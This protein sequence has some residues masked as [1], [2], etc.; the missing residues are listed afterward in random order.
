MSGRL[1][2]PAIGLEVHVQLAT[3]TK[4][5]C[6]DSAGFGAPPNT[7][8][9]PVCLGL[10][11]SLPVPNAAAV[12]LAVRAALALHC[13]VHRTSRF[14]RKHYFYP[15]L[16]KGYQITQ[17]EQ[18]LATAGWLDM[19]GDGAPPHRIRIRRVHLE[20]DA[21]RSVHDR[22]A[23]RTAIDL[24]RAGVPLIE[25]V[26]EPE[27][28]SPA[29]AR[30]FLARL[31]QLLQYAGVSDCDME[32]GGLRVDANIS[33]SP[34]LARSLGTR[35]EI[36]NLNSFG[37]AERA[38]RF[39]ARRQQQLLDQGGVVVQETREWD[40]GARAVRATR[41]KEETRD[42][43]FFPD[44]DLP[45]LRVPASLLEAERKA[46][47]ERPG[48][49]SGRFRS[50]YGLPGY[51]AGVLTASRA[52][53]D[54][55]EAV[56]AEGGDPKISSNWVMTEVRSHLSRLAVP[57]AAFPVPPPRLAA[58]I[59]LVEAGVVSTTMGRQ[60]LDR[61]VETGLDPAAI[62]ESER[63]ALVAEEGPVTAWVDDVL[64]DYPE[65]RRRL[66]EGD[67]RMIRFFMGRVMARSGG[68]A[69]PRL[70]SERLASRLPG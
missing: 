60:V 46:L 3:A 64:R 47:P 20:E 62:I 24:N 1:Y 50:E 29:E 28:R 65:E 32:K 42:Y 18:P 59:R 10:P 68:R 21:G 38:L 27:L 5:F 35:T 6:G 25:I 36:K 33:V 22:F 58:L 26:T 11:G 9:C 70:A 41:T 40:A 13:T 66:E 48:A 17:H 43:R 23:G 54:Y 7:L 16:P 12:A 30:T 53:A 31:K 51:D 14:D 4:L 39:E 44:P 19:A 52:L 37:N 45:P 15:D 49:R 56:V 67:R 63:L 55:Y 2:E 34:T 61:M 8:V 69:D 57:V